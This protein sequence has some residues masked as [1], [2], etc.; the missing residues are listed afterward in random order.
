MSR[1]LKALIVVL[2]LAGLGWFCCQPLNRIGRHFPYLSMPAAE[3]YLNV[4]ELNAFLDLWSRI[5]YGPLKNY[6]WQISLKSGSTYPR[7]LV[8]WLEAQGWSAER[9]FY[10]EQKVREL[11]EY[12]KLEGNIASNV[13]LSKRTSANLDEIVKEQRRHLKVRNFNESE[14]KLIKDNLYQINEI[15]AGRAV[16]AK[17]VK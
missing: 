10:D 8:K 13:K 14:I 15:F 3:E 16:L 12:V 17:P 4:T 11:L 6:M 9:F 1:K 5:N 7:P 2:C